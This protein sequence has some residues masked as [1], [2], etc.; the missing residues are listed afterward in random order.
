MGSGGGDDF[1]S[2]SG[3]FLL[4]SV[5]YTSRLDLLPLRVEYAD[6]TARVLGDPSLHAFIGGEPEIPEGL[7]ARYAR[8]VAGAP[9]PN[10]SW[11]NWVVRL[12]G[13]GCLV[14]TVQAT[15]RH[16][17]DRVLAEVAW[18]VGTSWQGHGIGREA[19]RGL[20]EWLVRQGVDQ[21]VAHVHP[22]HH[23]S[24]AVAASAGLRSTGR[25]HDGEIR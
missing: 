4:A 12:R 10:V 24:A 18:V 21:V 8:L 23:A 16:S 19:G 6:E 5:I 11:L 1:G 2:G 3:G 17:P 14:G 7:R 25:L 22:D 20:V 15:V 13:D 9:E